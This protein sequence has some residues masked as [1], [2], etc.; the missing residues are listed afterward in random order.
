MKPLQLFQ[1]MIVML[2]KYQS[3][4]ESFMKTQK[5]WYYVLGLVLLS[6]LRVTYGLTLLK[7]PLQCAPTCACIS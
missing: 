2:S 6:K 5:S 4:C 7:T 1:R 3:S